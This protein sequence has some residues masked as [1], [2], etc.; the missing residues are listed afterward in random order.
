MRLDVFDH[1][2]IE[3][4]WKKVWEKQ[5][6]YH[7][8][9]N[10][11]KKK[12]YCLDMYP[13]PSGDGLHVGHMEGYT[14]SDIYSRFMRMRGFNVLHPMGWDAF[15]LPAENF[16]IKTGTHPIENTKKAI[17]NFR[18]Q[19]K[20]LGLSYDWPREFSTNDP[21]YYKW[22]QWLFLFLFKRGLAYKGM[23]P[24]NWC[25]SCQT[26]LANEQV[27]NGKCERCDSS[28]ERK[29][30]AQWFFKITAYADRLL[31]GLNKLDWPES[32]KE[33]Q[34]NWIGRLEGVVINYQILNQNFQ[35]CDLSIDIFTTRP[36]TNFGAAFVVAAPD[37]EFVKKNIESFPN[38]KE[39]E[40][41][42]RNALRKLE[43]ERISERR[44]KT[45]VFTGL[46]AVN[47]FN[48]KKMPIYV[49]DFVLG[50]VGTGALVGVPGHDLRDFDF[51]KAMGLEV[52]RVVV[53]SDGDTSPITKREQVIEGDGTM[54]NSGFLDGLNT[55]EA[56]KKMI[57][58]IEK[59][60][61]GRRVVHYKM[62]D[63]L[64]S[65]QRYW[66]A[67]IP[68]VY[69]DRCGIVPIPEKELPVL[70]PDD[71]GVDELKPKGRSPLELSKKFNSNVKCPKCGGPG[72]REKDT[73]DTFVDSSWYFFRFT[74]PKNERQFASRDALKYWMPVDF[75]IG[76]AEHTVGHLIYS[77]FITKVLYDAGLIDFD[78]PFLK[79]RHP[80]IVLG[81]DGR[82]MSKRWGNIVNPDD[83]VNRV[84]AD[85]VRMYV[86]FMGP[87]K[88][89]KIWSTKGEEGVRRFVERLWKARKLVVEK[90]P[91]LGQKIAIHR[92]VK[93]TE[94]NIENMR[95][96]VAIS[97]FMV[98]VNEL[99]DWKEV[100]TEIWK[101]FL[102][103]VA[104]FAPFITEELWSQ[105]G[106]KGSIHM[107]R[108]PKYDSKLIKEEKVK[109][110]VQVNGKVRGEI[111][112][113]VDA[114]K[115]LVIE[116]ALK[117][118]NVKRYVKSKKDIKKVIYVKAKILNLLVNS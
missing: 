93:E 32:T 20:N 96:N 4:R 106:E 99:F 27:I 60:G 1:K 5:S 118:E 37:S 64:I 70:L 26:V 17:D 53:G 108:W 62:R 91:S 107:Q 110:A 29:E 86:M 76:G 111:E 42:V 9:I 50:D 15:G 78:E 7:V 59:K 97:K 63:W 56:I 11:K 58:Y 98:F 10:R 44:K 116:E 40:R 45:G 19:E 28:V 39:V 71:I 89:M 54:V 74:D 6:F 114:D 65:R 13:Y 87:L 30:L 35:K 100:P 31:D 48:N 81:E 12:Y 79:L 68:I 61:W 52:L 105:L 16:A 112:V 41:Y 92:L 85:A 18:K 2:K 103:V 23:A 24:V 51:A 109:I 80:G 95:F 115:D 73:M 43:L 25:P 46:Y 34:R 57:D 101:M 3:E 21:S 82:K 69:C 113:A 22:T 36:D 8:S 75:Y 72:E 67:P 117:A 104:P 66:G 38:K 14:A 94:E 77:R 84:G 33:G 47:R 88:D 49:S 102:V 90:K 83:E 55:R